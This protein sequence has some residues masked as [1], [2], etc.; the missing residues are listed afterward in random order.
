[1]LL[2]SDEGGVNPFIVEK[3]TFAKGIVDGGD[4]VGRGG[5]G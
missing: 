1:M 2:I 5:N 3:S 4:A